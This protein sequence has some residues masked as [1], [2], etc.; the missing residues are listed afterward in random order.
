[1]LSAIRR[2]IGSAW[3]KNG[4]EIRLFFLGRMPRFLKTNDY[5]KVKEDVPVFVFHSVEPVRFEKQLRYLADNGYNTIDTDGLNEI[6]RNGKKKSTKTVALTFDDATGSFWAVAFPLLKKYG[7]CAILFAIP[8]LVPTNNQVFPNLENTWTDNC[9]LETITSRERIQP[10][11]TWSELLTIHQSGFIDVQ[12][13]SLTH[14]RIN[15]SSKVVDFINPEFDTYFYENINIPVSRDNPSSERPQ[16]SIRYGQ[17]IFQSASRLSGYRRYLEDVSIGDRLVNYVAENGLES[18]YSRSSWRRELE[19]KYRNLVSRTGM[20]DEYENPQ[21]TQ[22][23]IRTELIKSKQTLESRLPGKIV[24]HLCYPWFQG[25]LLSDKIAEECGYQSVFY[26]FSTRDDSNKSNALPM[27]ISRI[28]EEYL[29]CLPGKGRQ[30]MYSVLAAKLLKFTKRE[31]V[32][33]ER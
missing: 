28:S 23:A 11:C 10:L 21:E 2:R 1:M 13:H 14:S 24:R 4:E 17:P 8:G 18:F 7:F 9:P 27:K 22:N 29:F 5:E 30:S 31:L 25:S 12:S 15:I 19:R 32:T 33:Y 26:G 20:I 16:R 6:L 3:V